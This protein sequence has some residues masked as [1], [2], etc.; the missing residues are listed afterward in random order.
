M[1]KT[2][3]HWHHIIP[4]HAGGT[5][6]PSNLVKLTV[7]EHAE[8]HRLLWEQHGRPQDKLSWL[9]LAGKTTEAE[10]ARATMAQQI[11]RR[12]WSD[13]AARQAQS[14]R[15]KGN[16]HGLGRKWTPTEE[17]KQRISES[18]KARYQTHPH[19][20]LGKIH[21][22][23]TK[24]KISESKKGVPLSQEHREHIAKSQIG[25]KQT[26]HQKQRARETRSATWQVTT[27]TGETFVITN[28]RQ[29]CVEHGLSQGNLVAHGHTKGYRALKLPT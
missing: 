21:S 22:E 13:P 29:Y 6:D 27:P 17:T 20:R 5:D 2:I 3:Y 24:R 26:A 4:I 10:T 12:R 11:Q 16:K 7:E 8:A 28:L 23:D 9:L 25:R 14:E 15:M 1:D 18:Q 19:N